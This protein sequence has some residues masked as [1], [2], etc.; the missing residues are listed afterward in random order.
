MKTKVAEALMYGKKVIGSKEAFVGYEDFIDEAGIICETADDFVLAIN[1]S[2][3]FVKNP[4]TLKLRKIYEENY[5][6]NAAKSR[7]KNIL[8]Q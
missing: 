8:M 4:C 6:N 1:S 7:L 5:S 2:K 3:L